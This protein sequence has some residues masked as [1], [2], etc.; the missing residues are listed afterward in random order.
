[1]EVALPQSLPSRSRLL[2]GAL[3]AAVL[4]LAAVATNS[5]ADDNANNYTCV[6]QTRLGDPEEGID[7]TQ[8]KY[9]FGCNGPIL[10]YQIATNR[11]VSSFDTDVIVLDQ[12]GQAVTTDSFT[13]NAFVPTWGINCIGIYSGGVNRVIGQ[14]AI[15]AK[16][17]CDEPRVDPLLTVVYATA[18]SKGKVTQ[19]ISGPY[20]LGRPHGC[21]ASKTGGVNRAPTDT[22]T[23]SPVGS[24]SI[25]ATT[26]AKATAKKHRK[27]A[28]KAKSKG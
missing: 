26:P 13:C 27:A 2:L 11:E 9:S 21:P 3:V 6:G 16:S 10:G 1:M 25:P 19:Y 12:Q 22:S 18:D 7:G 23:G 5:Y 28:A 14:F 17:I 4:V 15:D 24:A 8:V 20:D